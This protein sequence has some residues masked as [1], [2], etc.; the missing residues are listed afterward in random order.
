MATFASPQSIGTNA[1]SFVWLLP[2]VVAIAVVYKAL[3]VKEISAANFTRQAIVLSG[4][5]LVFMIVV[6]IGLYVVAWIITE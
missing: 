5:I 3:K 6:A 4:T 2:L 1:A